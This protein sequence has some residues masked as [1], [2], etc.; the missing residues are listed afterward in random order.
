[1]DEIDL[2]TIRFDRETLFQMNLSLAVIMF[3]VALRLR[4]K[5]FLDVCKFPKAFVLGF[6]SQ[7]LLLPLL[8]FCLVWVLNPQPS[9]A[10]GMLV[11]AACPGGN[12][13]N[14]FTSMAGG[15]AA[16][17]ISMTAVAS[18]L[19]V[20]ITP[21]NITLWGGWYPPAAELLQQIH[22]N[23]L[24][25]AAI[26]AIILIIPMMLGMFVGYYFK[27]FADNIHPFIQTLSICIFIII[28]V[29]AFRSNFDHFIRYIHLVA[30]LVFVHNAF[31]LLIG[32]GWA[33][34]FKLK[35]EDIKTITLETGIQNSGLGLGVIFT[36]FQGL[37]G[38]A[39]VAGWWGIWHIVSGLLL[40]FIWSKKPSLAKA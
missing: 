18:L 20:I 5:N 10:L 27:K 13:S 38:M 29:L 17:S 24:D 39:L 33:R 11:V 30:G 7:F 31:A 3:G 9:M 8:T 35:S 6:I 4:P 23:F 16:L 25:V 26:V 36:F 1:M 12:I 40:A 14:F 37:G 21:L 2:I 34:W 28:V 15:N 32:Y 22:I 19:A